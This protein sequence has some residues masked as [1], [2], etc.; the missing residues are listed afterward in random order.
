MQQLVYTM[1]FRGAASPS[2]GS[3]DGLRVKASAASSSITTIVNKGGLT[4][5]FDPSAGI[6]AQF[7]SEVVLVTPT[8]FTES[9]M[10]SFGDAGH[11]LRFVSIGQGWMGP[12]PDP[13]LKQGSVVWAVD[14]G[15]GQLTGASGLITSNF[16]VSEKGE[17]N[18]YHMGVIYLK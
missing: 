10:I 17:V 9:G 14:G 3:A 2:Q 4:G 5:G 7:E 18:D 1:H 6:N 16:T 13:T 15:E 11:K 8:T 12:S